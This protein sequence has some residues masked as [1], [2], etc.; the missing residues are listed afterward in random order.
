[1][2]KI[3]G[4]PLSTYWTSMP[5]DKK[6]AI[7]KTLT[8]YQR[9]WMSHTFKQYGSLY[10]AKDIPPLP[11]QLVFSYQNEDSTEI[12]DKRFTI[13]PTVH[14][15]TVDYGRAQVEFDRG[16]CMLFILSAKISLRND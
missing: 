6:T 2:E 10:Y 4:V 11:G 1:M 16:P 3:E 8:T 12:E 5:L 14:R 15:Q 7:M 9:S 13:G